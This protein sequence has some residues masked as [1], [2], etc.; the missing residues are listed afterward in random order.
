[1]DF[2][3]ITIRRGGGGD[4]PGGRFV[5]KSGVMEVGGTER[6]RKKYIVKKIRMRDGKRKGGIMGGQLRVGES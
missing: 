6:V 4:E 3:R 1:M 5:G 2:L